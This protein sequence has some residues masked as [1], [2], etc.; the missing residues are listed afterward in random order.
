M[1]NRSSEGRHHNVLDALTL[2]IEAVDLPQRIF[3]V[4]RHISAISKLL[5]GF[6]NS[7]TF[8]IVIFFMFLL[9]WSYDFYF[10]NYWFYY[11]WGCNMIT[12]FPLL[13]L[14]LKTYFL[15]FIP[16]MWCVVSINWHVLKHPLI[17]MINITCHGYGPRNVLLNLVLS[18]LWPSSHL[19]LSEIFSSTI[20]LRASSSGFGI[21][22]MLASCS[23]LRCASH[24]DLEM[25]GVCIQFPLLQ[26]CST[27]WWSLVVETVRVGS[28]GSS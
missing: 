21:W 9:R 15:S 13:F 17:P 18:I 19:C 6:N 10:L 24:Y 1:L 12:S 28:T 3:I 20:F 27:V 11:F 16:Q 2:A 14:T 5:Q 7:R 22:V 25:V 23:E 8:H 26:M 4:L